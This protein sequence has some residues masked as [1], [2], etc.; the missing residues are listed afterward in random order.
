MKLNTNISLEN[1]VE[2]Y[3]LYRDLMQYWHKT[4]PE[5]IF[6]LNYEELINYPDIT[7]K[8]IF[9]SLL[10]LVLTRTNQDQNFNGEV[11]IHHLK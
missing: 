6:D 11:N 8:N 3:L 10:I 7:V 5:F 2:Y 9:L 4:S 1:I